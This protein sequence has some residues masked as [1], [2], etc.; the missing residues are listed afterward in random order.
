MLGFDSVRKDLVSEFGIC[1]SRVESRRRPICA[2][3][4]EEKFRGGLREVCIQV[5]FSFGDE[6]TAAGYL[7]S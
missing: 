6:D 1:Q 7:G 3:E 5:L 2:R 4:K